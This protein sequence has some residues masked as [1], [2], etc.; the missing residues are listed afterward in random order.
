MS[1]MFIEKKPELI[2]VLETPTLIP[3]PEKVKKPRKPMSDERKAQLREQLAKARE[4]KKAK[5]LA[6]NP[7]KV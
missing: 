4:T 2:Q 3:T 5:K 6:S 1:E 7:I